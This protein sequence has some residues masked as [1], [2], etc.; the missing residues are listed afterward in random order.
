MGKREE[1]VR[2]KLRK[3]D[4]EMIFEKCPPQL[5]EQVLELGC[6][7]GYQSMFLK[8]YIQNLVATDVNKDLLNKKLPG[9]D[10]RV[11]DAAETDRRFSQNSLDLIFSSNVLEHIA[12]VRTVLEKMGRV[13]KEDGL[14]IHVMPNS[15]WKYLQYLLFPPIK[16]RNA[17]ARFFLKKTDG[18][19][20]SSPCGSNTGY[21][22]FPASHGK[23]VSSIAEFYRFGAGY[24]RRVFKSADVC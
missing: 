5:F 22:Y 8:R 21:E 15:L 3:K 16:L 2:R 11:M 17:A 10:I 6:G 14:M 9:I 18:F 23:Q 7:D 13:L 4:I 1:D 24:W 12:D 19:N 20:A